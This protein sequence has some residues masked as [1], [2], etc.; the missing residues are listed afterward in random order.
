MAETCSHMFGLGNA[1]RRK[2]RQDR[3]KGGPGPSVIPA[4]SSAGGVTV[5]AEEANAK[6]RNVF[7]NG[8]AIHLSGEQMEACRAVAT[9]LHEHQRVALAWMVKHENNQNAGLSGGILADD[10]GLGKT[11]SIIALVMTNHHDGRPLLK[12]ELGFER[13]S[14]V[15][16]RKKGNAIRKVAAVNV[17][18]LGVGNKIKAKSQTAKQSIFG[19]FKET[20]EE[21]E[22]KD[23]TFKFGGNNIE[24]NLKPEK[25]KYTKKFVVDESESEEDDEGEE[26]D[27]SDDDEEEGEKDDS[28]EDWNPVLN[29]DGGFDLES[30]SDDEVMGS[31]SKKRQRLE[32]DDSDTI[33]DG[34]TECSIEDEESDISL[35]DILIE[36]DEDATYAIENQ[37]KMDLDV[38]KEKK[39]HQSPK[40]VE[41]KGEGSGAGK[42]NVKLIIPPREPA[43][44]NGR[45][46]PTL[47]VCPKSLIHHWVQQL[48]EHLDKGV[49]IRVKIHHGQDKASTGKDLNIQDIVITTYGTLAAEFNSSTVAPLFGAKWLR[50]VLDEGH[51]IKNHRTQCAKGALHLSTNRRWVVSGTPIQN[52]LMELWSLVN[53][54]D[55]G[56]YAGQQ[57]AFK[58]QIETPCKNKEDIGFDRLRL[59]M[60]A[61]CLRRGKEDKKPDGTPLVDLPKKRVMIREVTFS[62]DEKLFYNAFLKKSTEIVTRY[63]SKGELMKHYGHVF[64]L[65]TRL[66]QLCMHWDLIASVDWAMARRDRKELE[67]LIDR[68]VDTM[69]DL[70][71]H[72]SL[73]ALK[74][75]LREMVAS[76]EDCSICLSPLQTPVI[77]P[78]G[79]VFCKACIRQV[80]DTAEPPSCPLCRAAVEKPALLEMEGPSGEMEQAADSTEQDT[81]K[82]MEDIKV[83]VSSS[84]INAAL[85]EIIR[86]GRDQP[87]DK[88]V[89]VSQMT[90]F[91]SILQP[92]LKDNKI[93]F[94]RLDGR[95]GSDL[96]R[97]V[98]QSFQSPAPGSPKLL[99][100]SF[101]VGGVGLNLTAA[102]HLL[103][104]DPA[105]NPAA[106]WQCFDRCHR[107][108]QSKDV[109][110]YKFITKDSIEESMMAIQEKK[111][112]LITGAFHMQ[113]DERRKTRLADIKTIFGL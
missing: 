22:K 1:K 73:P 23:A 77:T 58:E 99:L 93:P 42:T 88:I 11:L 27:S 104:L 21:R 35:P 46:R 94:T 64:A 68:A 100:L 57:R 40:K 44:R 108:G 16:T 112:E 43:D 90:S 65:M 18:N 86:I 72:A 80:L 96:Q 67:E 34:E 79:H 3:Y 78:C 71:Q 87:D 10:M 76:G 13:K 25:R 107:I 111:K 51:L 98:L 29:V 17:D 50:V 2:N 33:I 97:E 9:P 59:L 83:E 15:T 62:E 8:L 36:S 52:N 39:E 31:G 4:L 47:V 106:E 26:D 24:M 66:R 105:W 84:K 69:G 113:E 92:L 30:D 45:R 95:M 32:S 61:I 75:Q 41:S 102:N 101:R 20:R 74:A 54:L 19:K 12:P 110:I 5:T 109:N 81:L 63:K 55:F 6:M 89:V 37:D 103:L 49:D 60:D 85:K 82:A 7:E 91:L 14:I 56:M 48:H 38:E 28:D 53:W 70:P